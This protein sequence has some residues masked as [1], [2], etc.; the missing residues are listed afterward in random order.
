MAIDKLKFE[1]EPIVTLRRGDDHE[2]RVGYM[3]RDLALFRGRE[4][5]VRL[6][7]DDQGAGRESGKDT[8]ERCVVVLVGGLPVARKVVRIHLARDVDV[9]VRVEARYEF[10]ALVS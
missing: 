10:V 9:T 3:R 6:D 4:Q 2:L 5:A 7:A 1:Q 8:S